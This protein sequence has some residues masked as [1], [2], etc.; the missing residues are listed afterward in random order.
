METSQKKPNW[1]RRH[2]IITGIIVLILLS[3]VIDA[4]KNDK[5]MSNVSQTSPT[6]QAEIRKDE[7][8]ATQTPAKEEIKPMTVVLADFVKEFDDNQLSAES[9]YKNKLV[10]FSGYIKNISEDVM[11]SPYLA[12]QP[13][14]DEYYFDTY[15]QCYFKNKNDLMS[16]KNGQMIEVTGKVE[17]QSLG[18]VLIKDCSIGK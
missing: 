4:F 1:F 2:P 15:V 10:S 6:A 14:A 12:I 8:T 5:P 11:G 13:V 18:N 17:S 7:P 16:I 9:K 3:G